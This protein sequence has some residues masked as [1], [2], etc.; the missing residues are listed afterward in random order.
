MVFRS[1]GASH[2]WRSHSC[3]GTERNKAAAE[4]N[5]GWICCPPSLPLHSCACLHVLSPL[6]SHKGEKAGAQIGSGDGRKAVKGKKKILQK[7]KKKDPTNKHNKPTPNS[8]AK[9]RWLFLLDNTLCVREI[10]AL[11]APM[12]HR[13]HAGGREVRRGDGT[14]SVCRQ[15]RVKSSGGQRLRQRHNLDPTAPSAA[16]ITAQ[17]RG[18]NGERH[19]RH[20]FRCGPRAGRAA[21]MTRGPST[22]VA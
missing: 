9:Q 16:V 3:V 14:A 8:S 18:R 22:A 1:T 7:R 4:A 10:S 11:H 20:P 2:C 6:N 21:G 13:C 5:W 15:T 17:S 19:L 12:Q